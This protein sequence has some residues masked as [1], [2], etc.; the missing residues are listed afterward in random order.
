MQYSVL[1][2]NIITERNEGK[3][4]ESKEQERQNE[5]VNVDT[6]TRPLC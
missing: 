4:M 5:E 1:I 6:E 2:D 3:E